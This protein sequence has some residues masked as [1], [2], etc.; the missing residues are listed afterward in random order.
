MKVNFCVLLFLFLSQVANSQQ[1]VSGIIKDSDTKRPIEGV[2]VQGITSNTISDSLGTFSLRVA[3]YSS[4]LQ[5][6]HVSY[7]TL[8]IK[9][10]SSENGERLELFMTPSVIVL[11]E[12]SVTDM[13]S[14]LVL[15]KNVIDRIESN[16]YQYCYS[17]RSLV[18]ESLVAEKV[19]ILITE[20]TTNDQI[21]FKDSLRFS[22][23]SSISGIRRYANDTYDKY[24]K[25]RISGAASILSNYN[26]VLSKS[27]PFNINEFRTSYSFDLIDTIQV[28]ESIQVRIHFSHM[29]STKWKGEIMINLADYSVARFSSSRPVDRPVELTSYHV[30]EIQIE[31]EY[32][33][34]EDFYFTESVKVKN[35]LDPIKSETLFSLAEY[36][37]IDVSDCNASDLTSARLYD[38][39]L[40]SEIPDKVNHKLPWIPIERFSTYDH[41]FEDQ[42]VVDNSLNLKI[43]AYYGFKPCI[44][45]GDSQELMIEFMNQ[46]LVFED[47]LVVDRSLNYGMSALFGIEIGQLRIE[48]DFLDPFSDFARISG[49]FMNLIYSMKPFGKTKLSLG[50]GTKFGI[51]KHRDLIDDFSLSTIMQVGKRT[52][53][54]GSTDVFVEQRSLQLSPSFYMLY[55][56]SNR[57]QIQ[58]ES[59][60]LLG[61]QTKTGLYFRENDDF[62]G[63]KRAFTTSNSHLNGGDRIKKLVNNSLFISI[64]FRTTI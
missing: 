32:K 30:N 28:E 56:V 4:S 63:K 54:S 3:G 50:L 12:V 17:Q 23:K 52:F 16:Y 10:D 29:N 8:E 24:P 27:G 57:T 43:A 38:N 64:G 6:S 25:F 14:E 21:S 41:L 48:A 44:W 5:V 51:L 31:L 36:Q 18:R 59:T 45:F 55:D 49:R 1:F 47:T 58:L 33:K 60:Y 34:N 11:D 62:F 19:P 9:I 61:F 37:I 7:T 20:A 53:D 35:V 15:M 26:P 40:L 46:S 42:S 22:K 2:H 13:S 39:D